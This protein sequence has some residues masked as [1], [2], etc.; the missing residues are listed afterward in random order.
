MFK[1]M[2]FKRG[3]V[4]G[5]LSLSV[6]VQ[7]AS[8]FMQCMRLVP[9]TQQ[10]VSLFQKAVPALSSVPS[11]T[12]LAIPSTIRTLRTFLTQSAQQAQQQEQSWWQKHKVEL[13]I[14]VGVGTVAF[15]VTAVNNEA[16]CE[17]REEHLNG[18]QGSLA[19]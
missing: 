11:T 4:L 2:M 19:K 18:H 13:G 17:G 5:L 16:E 14:A 8:K 1:E 6:S 10:T 7:G 12:Q 15:G 3:I 9:K